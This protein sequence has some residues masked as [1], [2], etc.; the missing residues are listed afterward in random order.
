MSHS[1][2]ST[3]PDDTAARILAAAMDRI[4][5]YGYAK[6]T[7]AEIARDCAMSAGNIYRFFPSKL[8]IAQALAEQFNNK[9]F[10]EYDKITRAKGRSAMDRL[11][12][13]F[14][15]QLRRSFHLMDENPQIIELGRILS[16]ERPEF[17]NRELADQR[18]YVTKILEDGNS[19]SEFDVS[20]PEEVAEMIQAALLKFSFPQLFSRLSLPQL[21]RELE[22]VLRIL[23]HGLQAR[24]S[25]RI[26]EL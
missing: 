2:A 9:V 26:R 10:A 17:G 25:S 6:T 8:D 16:I 20:D 18:V 3:P 4:L 5:H 15:H 23:M 7:M 19:R 12:D 21:E 11:A 13:L 24:P 14:R 22:G 1:P